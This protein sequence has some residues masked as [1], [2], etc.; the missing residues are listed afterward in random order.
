[1]LF[2]RVR[3][4]I[5]DAGMIRPGEGVLVAL[6][7]G[8]DSVA[9]LDV[10]VELREAG[11]LPPGVRLTVGHV[12]H[13]LRD[14]ADEDEAFC[15]ELSAKL[16]L[17]YGFARVDVAG[18]AL[19]AKLSIEDAARRLRYR[20]LEGLARR[21]GCRRIA[22]GHT[23]DDQAETFLL[24]LLRGAGAKGLGGAHPVVRDRFVRPLLDARRHE[25]AAY[26]EE[27]GLSFREDASN[28]DLRF[29]RN[30][31]RRLAVPRLVQDF[32][33]RLVE[34]LAA[35][36]SLLR[37]EDDWM[38]AAARDVW[39][40]VRVR[41]T[42]AGRGEGAVTLSVDALRELHVALRRRVVRLSFE[43]L[44]GDLRGIG[45]GHVEA[46]LGLLR[47]G[48][49]GRELHLP[50]AVVERSFD[51]LCFRRRLDPGRKR[52]PV[53]TGYNGYEYRLTIPARLHVHESGGTLSATL[54]QE[55]AGGSS[56]TVRAE[57]ARARSDGPRAAGDSVVVAAPARAE[58]VVRSPRT[59]DRFR[60]L[61][62]PGSKPLTRYLMERRVS[63]E[64]RARV[65]LVVMRDGSSSR[66]E[67]L[68]VAGHA[69]SET[70][71]L[72]TGAPRLR[73]AWTRSRV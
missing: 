14:E 30:R 46:A 44:R 7:G 6:S 16:G 32:N 36:A 33:P 37:D 9:L 39:E 69:V 70:A 55:A 50:G 54:E 12:H 20:A 57:A 40:R 45:R 59:G 26:L 19:R 63:R 51:R 60:P 49:S 41:E 58:L 17:P 35:T 10:L 68:W 24:R 3:S 56:S 21:H 1:M 61:G 34:T 43:A 8:P 48:K 27:R 13:G 66:D 53:D 71:R 31:L 22:L 38:E 28:R 5:V 52:S 25:I 67:V 47:S 62:A 15:R 2:D 4:T 11:T 72:R 65:P 73:L 29:T 23:Q 64:E 42:H 18:E